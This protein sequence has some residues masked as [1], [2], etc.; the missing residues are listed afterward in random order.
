VGWFGD[1]AV[2][3]FRFSACIVLVRGH[4][5]QAEFWWAKARMT[6]FLLCAWHETTG[7]A[8]KSQARA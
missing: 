8:A 4:V 2:S 3:G 5:S 1:A 7:I 6:L